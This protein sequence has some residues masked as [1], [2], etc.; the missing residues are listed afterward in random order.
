L[1]GLQWRS[2]SKLPYPPGFLYLLMDF[3]L[4]LISHNWFI[5]FQDVLVSSIE[6][7]FNTGLTLEAGI[8]PGQKS[9][10]SVKVFYL[11]LE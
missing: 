4:P 2:R 10:V 7:R 1:Q 11:A 5:V 3:L 8:S 9:Y 6:C